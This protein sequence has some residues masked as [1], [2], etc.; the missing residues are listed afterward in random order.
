M[1]NMQ[2]GTP[3]P[4]PEALSYLLPYCRSQL[5][6]EECH[7]AVFTQLPPADLDLPPMLDHSV[8]YML[9]PQRNFYEER[10]DERFEGSSQRGDLR[11]VPPGRASPWGCRDARDLLNEV[12]YP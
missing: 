8:M 9:A 5:K 11:L 1:V 10:G 12:P 3:A 6:L 2:S 7:I 4:P